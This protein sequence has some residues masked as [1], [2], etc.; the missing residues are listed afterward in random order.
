MT[1]K[2]QKLYDLLE[3]EA[4]I[5]KAAGS[6]PVNDFNLT[7]DP[8]YA[9]IYMQLAAERRRISEEQKERS[10]LEREDRAFQAKEDW[11]N[12][13]IKSLSTDQK[14][15]RQKYLDSINSEY[16]DKLHEISQYAKEQKE[17]IYQFFEATDKEVELL[18]QKGYEFSWGINEKSRVFSCRLHEDVTSHSLG[19]I[20]TH[21]H[22]EPI[23]HKEMCY[24]NLDL[25]CQ[26]IKNKALQEQK[27]KLAQL[28]QDEIERFH[29]EE[30]AL[31]IIKRKK[32]NNLIR[33]LD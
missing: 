31:S 25:E 9:N 4:L 2:E 7:S 3:Q 16:D 18:I 11:Y 33:S 19:V 10:R 21:L 17:Y 32:S 29:I 20:I 24:E 28:K 23:Q 26:E 6:T 12:N 22:Q 1:T 15:A 5:R 8:T 27:D 30:S 14:E 13:K